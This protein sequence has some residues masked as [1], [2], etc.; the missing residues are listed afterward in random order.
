MVSINNNKI[1]CHSQVLL[2]SA[3]F[4]ND[5]I[6]EKFNNTIS[7][8]H[9][10][11]NAIIITSASQ[12]KEKNKYNILVFKQLKS[13]GFK[14]ISFVDVE[15]EQLSLKGIDLLWINGGNTFRLLKALK[16]SNFL[17]EFLK[18]K[19]FYVGVSAGSVILG[20]NVEIAKIADENY[21]KLDNFDGFNIV[22]F[23]VFPHYE[24]NVLYEKAIKTFRKKHKVKIKRL[25]DDEALFF[26]NN[27]LSKWS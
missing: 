23:V 8:Q 27:T 10:K 5:N 18:F 19:G 15:K 12:E 17:E 20:P 6:K 2:T 11:I 3:G 16:G 14:N 7:K 22:D 24:E 13:L 4:L 21:V 1:E 25:R 9:K 26:S